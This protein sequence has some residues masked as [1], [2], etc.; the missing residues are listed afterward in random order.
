MLNDQILGKRQARR[1]RRTKQNSRNEYQY[2]SLKLKKKIHKYS[3]YEQA[4]HSK[5]KGESDK[6]HEK[7]RLYY[8]LQEINLRNKGTDRLKAK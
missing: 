1:N 7:E 2:G 5:Q 6:L 8:F 4:K 3:K